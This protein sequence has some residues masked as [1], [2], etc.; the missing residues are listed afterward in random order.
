MA[1]DESESHKARSICILKARL[2]RATRPELDRLCRLLRID[3]GSSAEKIEKTYIDAADNSIFSTVRPLIP[4]NAPTYLKVLILIYKELRSY[5]EA[6]DESWRRVK[7]LQLF[8]YVSPIQEMHELELEDKIL[9]MYKAEFKDAEDKVKADPTFFKRLTAYIPGL[10]STGAGAT[11]IQV[12][13]RGPLGMFGSSS[14]AGPLG[15]AL[16]VVMIGAQ[17]SGPAYR[18]IVPATVEIMLIGRRIEFTP[19]E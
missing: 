19:K 3:E 17:L 7:N 10:G 11:A 5:S 12:A 8:D 15:I 1:P 4:S 6:L 14:I 2:E 18:K 16:G 9:E 13:A